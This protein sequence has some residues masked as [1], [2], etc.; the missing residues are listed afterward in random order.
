MARLMHAQTREEVRNGCKKFAIYLAQFG[1]IIN[2]IN[3]SLMRGA[4]IAASRSPLISL[5]AK[6]ESVK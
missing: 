2:H 3:A 1:S 4:L 5:E 6:A